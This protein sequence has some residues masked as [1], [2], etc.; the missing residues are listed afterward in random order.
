MLEYDETE[1]YN[2]VNRRREEEE[3][4][5]FNFDYF[6]QRQREEQEN[7]EYGCEND[8]NFA[9]SDGDAD[10]DQEEPAEK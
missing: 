1:T 3:I 10:Y 2:Q 8:N 6:V 4:S 9:A 5:R 7:G